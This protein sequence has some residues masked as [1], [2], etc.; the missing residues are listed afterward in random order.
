MIPQTL[1]EFVAL[2]FFAW[3]L[4]RLFEPLRRRVEGWILRRLDPAKADIVDAEIVPRD[5]KK[6]KE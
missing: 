3:A 6:T 1:A 2:A 5:R 4:Y